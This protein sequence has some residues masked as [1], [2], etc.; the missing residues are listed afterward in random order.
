MSIKEKDHLVE[1]FKKNAG[2]VSAVIGHINSDTDAIDYVSNLISRKKLSNPTIAAPEFSDS[3]YLELEDKIRDVSLIKNNLSAHNSG[4]DISLTGAEFG[5]AETGTLVVKSKN[6]NR[7]LATMI[8]DIHVCC[9]LE[10]NIVESLDNVI[11]ELNQTL[12]Q[13]SGYLAFITGASR[14]ADIE[15]VL[16]VGVHGPLELHI[17]IRKGA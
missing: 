7:R 9:I 14:T 4:I 1:N 12:A 6:I 8:C 16:V 17:L 13:S 10:S 3:F 5:I 15:R 2:L 11:D